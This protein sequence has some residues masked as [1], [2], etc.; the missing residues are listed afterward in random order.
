MAGSM[1]SEVLGTSL[2]P[3]EEAHQDSKTASESGT[4]VKVL[5]S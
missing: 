4:S 5:Q 2:P 3:K 1:I